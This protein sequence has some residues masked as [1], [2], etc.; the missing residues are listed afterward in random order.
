MRRTWLSLIA[1]LAGCSVGGALDPP[2]PVAPLD[3]TPIADAIIAG[4][5][6]EPLAISRWGPATPAAVILAV[7]G[8]GDYGPST[9]AQAAAHWAEEG[10][11]TYAYDQRGF[12]RNPSRGF[13]PGAEELRRDLATIARQVRARHPCRALVVVGHSM[14]GGVALAAA[15]HLAE[16]G[17]ADG[18]ILA[19]PAIWGGDALNPLHRAA[20]WATAAVVP[21]RRIS[22]R[23]LVR[24]QPSDNI[25]MLRDLGRDPLYLAPPSAREILGLV[26]IVDR[27]A[28]AAPR[29]DLPALLL[30][31]TKDEIVPNSRVAEVFA[32]LPG[33]R[34]VRRYADGWHMLFRDNQAR[35]V[36]RDVAD[37]TLLQTAPD[38]PEDR[39]VSQSDLALAPSSP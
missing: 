3:T 6:G 17:S 39:I 8:F 33:P 26:R 25:E 20:A 19:A 28:A 38:C 11:A 31:G 9:F 14:G 10:I 4:E 27:A 21:E 36:W 1:L 5:G 29:A 2:A 32:R 37:W 22:G 23:G 18:I 16:A 24:I 30:L 7:H 13:W 35:R 12:G 34:G 15:P